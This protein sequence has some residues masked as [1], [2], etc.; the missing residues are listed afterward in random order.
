MLKRTRVTAALETPH[1]EENLVWCATLQA[2]WDALTDRN[3][4]PVHLLRNPCEAALLDANRGCWRGLDERSYLAKAGIGADGILESIRAEMHRKF[5]DEKATLLPPHVKPED[6]LAYS[7]LLKELAFARPLY[8]PD[9]PMHFG[10]TEVEGFGVWLRDEHSEWQARRELVQVV[11]Y[12]SPSDFVVELLPSGPADTILIAQVP[13]QRTLSATVESALRRLGPKREEPLR[14]DERLLVPCID[15]DVTWAFDELAGPLV[16][17]G[18]LGQIVIDS[19]Q[20][21]IRLRLDEEGARLRSEALVAMGGGYRPP[22]EREF[23]VDGPFLMLMMPRGVA[24]P[25]LVAWIE[26]DEVLVRS[27]G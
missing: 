5:P 15:L 17:N 6:A 23:V 8:T 18:A 24:Q 12:R 10:R 16:P 20:Q 21:S 3:E 2:A 7:F 27:Q 22:P 13:R 25:Y 19:V 11:S 9:W 26:N 14:A 1:G 4:S